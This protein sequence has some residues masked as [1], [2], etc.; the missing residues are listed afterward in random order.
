MINPFEDEI[1]TAPSIAKAPDDVIATEEE[2]DKSK[3]E[4]D[5]N[6]DYY[7]INLPDDKNPFKKIDA[8][9]WFTN[10]ESRKQ[11]AATLAEQIADEYENSDVTVPVIRNGK[12]EQVKASNNGV[13]TDAGQHALTQTLMMIDQAS[14]DPSGG[15]RKN[16]LTGKTEAAFGSKFLTPYN[17]DDKLAE[18]EKKRVAGE[19]GEYG[20]TEYQLSNDQVFDYGHVSKVIDAYAKIND[21]KP[22]ELNPESFDAKSFLDLRGKVKQALPEGMLELG[23]ELDQTKAPVLDDESQKIFDKSIER[24]FAEKKMGDK[25]VDVYDGQ[26]IVNYEALAETGDLKRFE[27]E[28]NALELTPSAKKI[29]LSSFKKEFEGQAASLLLKQAQGD[30]YSDDSTKPILEA[31]EK[32]QSFYNLLKEDPYAL[33]STGSNAL[34]FMK[35]VADHATSITAGAT[36]SIGS[37]GQM[38]LAGGAK[39]MGFDE[40]AADVVSGI[41]T[42]SDQIGAFRETRG[43]GKDQLDL[44]LFSVTTGDIHQLISEGAIAFATMGASALL[45]S[46]RI[47][48]TTTIKGA[49]NIGLQSAAKK[50][51][52]KSAKSALSSVSQNL[53]KSQ[54]VIGSVWKNAS[55]ARTLDNVLATTLEG[56]FRSAASAWG[57]SYQKNIDKGL[58]NVDAFNESTGQAVANG[59]ATFVAG[60]IMNSIAPGLDKINIAPDS[61]LSLTQAIKNTIAN[62]TAQKSISSGLKSFRNN[63]KNRKDLVK[64]VADTIREEA[65]KQGLKNYLGGV[66]VQGLGEGVEES[67]DAALAN[68]LDQYLNNSEEARKEFEKKGYWNQI[69]KAGFLGAIMGS[70]MSTISRTSDKNLQ[71]A[72]DAKAGM[73]RFMKKVPELA[74][75]ADQEIIV[76]GA[77]KDALEIKTTINQILQNGT[78]DQQVEA[79]ANI[80]KTRAQNLL[81]PT[82]PG[83]TQGTGITPAVD[84]RTPSAESKP[85]ATDTTPAP[86][87]GSTPIEQTA[88]P[89]KRSATGAVDFK[90]AEFNDADKGVSF[91]VSSNAPKSQ[92]LQLKIAATPKTVDGNVEVEWSIEKETGPS[93]GQY[94]K[95]R[96]DGRESAVRAF[97]E[98]FV[99]GIEASQKQAA[100]AD[101]VASQ[102]AVTALNNQLAQLR[103]TQQQTTT[104]T[105]AEAEPK[106]EAPTKPQSFTLTD[107][108]GGQSNVK[109]LVSKKENLSSYAYEKAHGT[110]APAGALEPKAKTTTAT[111]MVNGNPQSVPV[112]SYTIDGKDADLHS[113]TIGDNETVFFKKS[114]SVNA[115]KGAV[116]GASRVMMKGE[117]ASKNDYAEQ[118]QSTP[119]PAQ[120]PESNQPEK[121]SPESSEQTT[122]SGAV[123]TTRT[124]LSTGQEQVLWKKTKYGRKVG[125][126]WDA[127]FPETVVSAEDK[128]TDGMPEEYTVAEVS[129]ILHGEKKGGEVELTIRDMTPE[130]MAEAKSKMEKA[131]A[132]RR[133]LGI[134]EEVVPE[135]PAA[136]TP[137]TE[138]SKPKEK[139]QAPA[140]S[141]KKK[142]EVDEDDGPIKGVNKL[143]EPLRKIVRKF[144]G[145]A[146]NIGAQIIIVKDDIDLEKQMK[147]LGFDDQA[148][149]NVGDSPMFFSPDDNVIIVR[150]NRANESN[151]EKGIKHEIFH[152]VEKMFAASDAG[153]KLLGEI[154]IAKLVNDP[155]VVEYMK[156]EYS[157]SYPDMTNNQK[158]G[159]ITRAFVAGK[160]HKNTL[161]QTAFQ[162]YLKAFLK[163]ARKFTKK[164]TEL[165]SYLDGLEKF[166]LDTLQDYKAEAGIVASESSGFKSWIGG[167][168]ASGIKAAKMKL[169]GFESTSSIKASDEDIARIA[170]E[171]RG[172]IIEQV[173]A[174]AAFNKPLNAVTLLENIS[175]NIN[176]THLG[177]NKT[178]DANSKIAV[179]QNVLKGLEG[180][181]IDQTVKDAIASAMESVNSDRSDLLMSAPD[182]SQEVLDSVEEKKQ[183]SGWTG[184]RRYIKA[185]DLFSDVNVVNRR[186]FPDQ[187]PEVGE[188]NEY[189]NSYIS[190]DFN[191]EAQSYPDLGL[192]PG[193]VVEMIDSLGN[194]TGVLV[195]SHSVEVASQ[196]DS[197]KRLQYRF[198]KGETVANGKITPFAAI[199]QAQYSQEFY[200]MF[201]KSGIAKTMFGDVNGRTVINTPEGLIKM[202]FESLVSKNAKGKAVIKQGDKTLSFKDIF[203]FQKDKDNKSLT[204]F[205]FNAGDGKIY[206]DPEKLSANFAFIDNSSLDSDGKRQ[207]MALLVASTVRAAIEEEL[208]HLATVGT[209]TQ[210]EL[211]EFADDLLQRNA[212]EG[213]VYQVR[214]M[215][216]ITSPI[217]SMTDGEKAI[218]A[219][220]VLSFLHQKSAEGATYGDQYE[221]LFELAAG[222]GSA[223][224]QTA[225][226]YGR[227]MRYMLGARAATSF[228][229]PRMQKMVEVLNSRKAE[230]GVNRRATNM[231]ELIARF[232]QEQFRGSKKAMQDAI[233]QAFVNQAAEV[234]DL[235]QMLKENDIPVQNVLNVDFELNTVSLVPEFSDYYKLKYG[236]KSLNDLNDYFSRLNQNEA[237]G[238]LADSVRTA[239]SR[240]DSLRLLMDTTSELDRLVEMATNGNFDALSEYLENPENQGVFDFGSLIQVLNGLKYDTNIAKGIERDKARIENAFNAVFD[241]QKQ[242]ANKDQAIGYL[243]NLLS[244]YYSKNEIETDLEFVE[245]IA[246]EMNQSKEELIQTLQSMA[247]EQ[248]GMFASNENS[249]RSS[250]VERDS[251]DKL[252]ALL[253]EKNN[254]QPESPIRPTYYSYAQS[255]SD[256]NDLVLNYADILLNKNLS[257]VDE[258]GRN[259]ADVTTALENPA[260]TLTFNVNLFGYNN[261]LAATAMGHRA[262]REK[263]LSD[264]PDD[265][266]FKATFAYQQAFVGRIISKDRNNAIDKVVRIES[267]AAFLG[268]EAYNDFWIARLSGEVPTIGG[269]QISYKDYHTTMGFQPLIT[270]ERASDGTVE[271]EDLSLYLLKLRIPDAE[272]DFSS[273]IAGK[274]PSVRNFRDNFLKLAQSDVATK[275]TAARL[276]TEQLVDVAQIGKWIS[277]L[278]DLIGYDN[279]TGLFDVVESLNNKETFASKFAKQLIYRIFDNKLVVGGTKGLT[280][281]GADP[282]NPTLFEH[283][284]LIQR[285]YDATH[286]G[287]S[288]KKEVNK[289]DQDLLL[290]SLPIILEQ[291]DALNSDIG[292]ARKANSR[293]KSQYVASTI[294]GDIRLIQEQGAEGIRANAELIKA[295]QDSYFDIQAMEDAEWLTNYHTKNGPV[296][297]S[298]VTA[299]QLIDAFAKI[300]SS[301]MNEY[302]VTQGIQGTNVATLLQR[303]YQAQEMYAELGMGSPRAKDSD[304]KTTYALDNLTFNTVERV[305]DR[306][307]EADEEFN[308]D[309][310]ALNRGQETAGTMPQGYEGTQ[311]QLESQRRKSLMEEVKRIK[312][313]MFASSVS[314]FQS[315]DENLELSYTSK[316]NTNRAKTFFRL[317]AEA[318][319]NGESNNESKQRLLNLVRDQMV[320]LHYKYNTNEISVDSPFVVIADNLFNYKH[321]MEFLLDVAEAIAEKER[322]FINDLQAHSKD[323]GVMVAKELGKNVESKK[324]AD[325]NGDGNIDNVNAL[326]SESLLKSL[327][328]DIDKG[329]LVDGTLFHAQMFKM[330]SS[331]SMMDSILLEKAPLFSS[332]LQSMPNLIIYQPSQYEGKRNF[333]EN[334]IEF[335]TLPN[336]DV[337]LYIGNATGLGSSKQAELLERVLTARI[338]Q[339]IG[340]NGTQSPLA[341]SIKQIASTIREQINYVFSTTPERI[342]QM[343]EKAFSVINGNPN[344]PTNVVNTLVERYRKALESDA[345]NKLSTLGNPASRDKFVSDIVGDRAGDMQSF[346]DNLLS[347]DLEANENSILQDMKLIVDMFTNPDTYK[348]LSAIKSPEVELTSTELDP[349]YKEF[350]DT[351]INRFVSEEV[352]SSMVYDIK[353]E[354]GANNVFDEDNLG[355]STPEA[356]TT[357]FIVDEIISSWSDNFLSG[358]P[359]DDANNARKEKQIKSVIE[360]SPLD[361]VKRVVDG[362]IV[363]NEV[364]G[365]RESVNLTYDQIATTTNI[366]KEVAPTPDFMFEFVFTEMVHA[367]AP[368]NEARSV[369]DGTAPA[370]I[371]RPQ[372]VFELLQTSSKPVLMNSTGQGNFRSSYNIT[373]F[374][375]NKAPTTKLFEMRRKEAF[376]SSL[377]SATPIGKELLQYVY[378]GADKSG[379][380][381]VQRIDL[382]DAQDTL[383]A[384]RNQIKDIIGEDIFNEA[385]EN[386]EILESRKQ[387]DIEDAN[388]RIE[389]LKRQIQALR[390]DG[391]KQLEQVLLANARGNYNE[392]IDTILDLAVSIA[393]IVHDI[394]QKHEVATSAVVK[395][396]SSEGALEKLNNYQESITQLER[397]DKEI[398]NHLRDNSG[399]ISDPVAYNKAYS[400]LVL[401]HNA[402]AG[403]ARD[404]LDSYAKEIAQSIARNSFNKAYDL[405]SDVSALQEAVAQSISRGLNTYTINAETITLQNAASINQSLSRFLMTTGR[406][407]NAMNIARDL[408]SP[409][410]VSALLERVQSNQALTNLMQEQVDAIIASPD[411]NDA[412][413]ELFSRL[414]KKELSKSMKEIVSKFDP[415]SSLKQISDLVT[416]ELLKN[417]KLVDKLG[418]EVFSGDVKMALRKRAEF[419]SAELGA[420]REDFSDIIAGNIAKQI[421]DLND[422]REALLKAL[423]RLEVESEGESMT[424]M[425]LSKKFSFDEMF[426]I[427]R[428]QNSV[429]PQFDARLNLVFD[430]RRLDNSPDSKATKKR[431]VSSVAI[432]NEAA[433]LFLEKEGENMHRA[434]YEDVEMFGQGYDLIQDFNNVIDLARLRNSL[435][436][437]ADEMFAFRADE[438]LNTL[439]TEADE[440]AVQLFGVT[441]QDM[442]TNNM[443]PAVVEGTEEG[444]MKLTTVKLHNI[445][446]KKERLRRTALFINDQ[447][448]SSMFMPTTTKLA[449][450]N[451]KSYLVYSTNARNELAKNKR[452]TK[453]DWNVDE[454]LKELIFQAAQNPPSRGEGGLKTQT[455]K[456]I[457]T[458]LNKQISESLA[459]ETKLPKE[460]TIGELIKIATNRFT[461]FLIKN[462]IN[463]EM[464]AFAQG[465][466]VNGSIKRTRAM[467]DEEFETA[468]DDVFAFASNPDNDATLQTAGFERLDK[469]KSDY[470]LSE[471]KNLVEKAYAAAIKENDFLNPDSKVSQSIAFYEK[472]LVDI[473]TMLNSDEIGPQMG[474]F[475]E[476]IRSAERSI[477]K[478]VNIQTAVDSASE[479]NPYTI[480]R[481]VMDLDLSHNWSR[482]YSIL[483]GRETLNKL[484]TGALNVKT[485]D[486][487]VS[488]FGI[489]ENALARRKFSR[490]YGAYNEALNLI[491]LLDHG[492]DGSSGRNRFS[493]EYQALQG[494]LGQASKDLD[495]DFVK[496]AKAMVIASLRGIAVANEKDNGS[497]AQYAN[498]VWMWANAWK[499]GMKQHEKLENDRQKSH[500]QGNKF[501][502]FS[503]RVMKRGRKQ[504]RERAGTELINNLITDEVNSIVNIIN[505]NHTKPE[506]L[507]AR[508]EAMISKLESGYEPSDLAAI[509]KYS[510]ALLSEFTEI[511]EAYRITQA[512]ASRDNRTKISDE[513]LLDSTVIS[514][515]L[516]K[517]YSVFPLRFGYVKNPLHVSHEAYSHNKAPITDFIG[518]EQGVI[519]YQGKRTGLMEEESDKDAIRPLDLNP[520][521]APDQIAKDAMYRMYVAPTY[522][523]I[524]KLLG[525]SSSDNVRQSI[526]TNGFL[527]GVANATN[528]DSETTSQYPYIA[529]YIMDTIDKTIKNDKPESV[530]DSMLSDYLRAAATLI[531]VKYLVEPW[532]IVSQGVIPAVS[533]YLTVKLNNFIGTTDKDTAI[534]REAYKDAVLGYRNPNSPIARFVKENSIKNYKWMTEGTDTRQEQIS[535]TKYEGESRAVYVSRK[536]L[537][538]SKGLGEGSLDVV[539]GAPER[540]NIQAIYAFEL[541]HQLQKMMGPEAPKTL[542]EMY[543]MDPSS[544]NTLAKTKAD[545][546]VTDF[547]GLGDKSKKAGAYNIRSKS[548]IVSMIVQSFT[549]FSNHTATVGANKGVFAEY[550]WNNFAARQGYASPEFTKEAIENITGTFIQNS[551][552][553]VTKLPFLVA[554]GTYAASL[555]YEIVEESF[556]DDDEEDEDNLESIAQRASEWA[557]ALTQFDENG[558]LPLQMLKEYLFPKNMNVTN[559]NTI[560]EEGYSGAYLD[561]LWRAGQ[562]IVFDNIDLFPNSTASSITSFIPVKSLVKSLFDA[563]FEAGSKFIF[564]EEESDYAE[565]QKKAFQAERFAETFIMPITEPI[566]AANNVKNLMLNYALPK[567]GYEGISTGE[568]LN[569]IVTGLLGTR[570]S[571][572]SVPKRHAEQGGWGVEN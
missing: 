84:T 154:D 253:K 242:V 434:L 337:V 447:F 303:Y 264:S 454:K 290:S 250:I 315:F 161:G 349:K 350:F 268:E 316:I 3:E 563:A 355:V 2:D 451:N 466:R 58:S 196:Q 376:V 300:P 78:L 536:A 372:N 87:T 200:D 148:I 172:D 267:N 209:F 526:T 283:L 276:I 321:P 281:N 212:F 477:G 416:T 173:N 211:I 543:Q 254:A 408:S 500:E 271:P 513:Q 256:Y 463:K 506:M 361:L 453:A 499:N 95:M 455:H 301:A 291:I 275:E 204:P 320:F 306:P 63:I 243:S 181:D 117:L 252:L 207:S 502:R 335:A 218:V 85:P 102:S 261:E 353:L 557:T 23:A 120:K 229:S 223:R 307:S 192:N 417:P 406:K 213:I 532:Q 57:E 55:K 351:A 410:N 560:A 32:G 125:D 150:S 304:G 439:V 274:K 27:S 491:G 448:S 135:I 41:A 378:D 151:F 546:L 443:S 1:F 64:G 231:S 269:L 232:N 299:L 503:N 572:R 244:R 43:F 24:Y 203:V 558:F 435:Q 441:V 73:A 37:I 358:E 68:A 380:Y 504:D 163:F 452:Q 48:A 234:N 86:E 123:F 498:R 523:V 277:D 210:K 384:L 482:L 478:L 79:I 438:A 224:I 137:T 524:N 484:V 145:I 405:I 194:V 255:V 379:Q 112:T 33:Q 227:R 279:K 550:L 65:S 319:V 377:A 481:A 365:G 313:W 402:H 19:K 198:I 208:L 427:A 540:A 165:K 529:A 34:D 168:L 138:T 514:D 278:Q 566:I 62:R 493:A 474:S 14:K 314:I 311:E 56:S 9:S 507:N 571:R 369:L 531:A 565:L 191:K 169:S 371:G 124:R 59:L 195:Y 440:K 399:L 182:E 425:Q 490:N 517:N 132:Q 343:E 170:D 118:L 188:Q 347:A 157:K 387:K 140:P 263:A 442:V 113:V 52:E 89:F 568:F 187:D 199:R 436:F 96:A 415:K 245:R 53:I 197:V 233:N 298:G 104:E 262:A 239:R 418:D 393:G 305:G 47:A 330:G 149:K 152:A 66:A 153:K 270:R 433:R 26:P 134:K 295:I 217:D 509:R 317:F 246:S 431:I 533:K 133:E 519:N 25:L 93:S 510:D 420:E 421:D 292:L 142:E 407:A 160:L 280:V 322:A 325:L 542:Q 221:E 382:I 49:V 286:P 54:S 297:Y 178:M 260:S 331:Q 492:L 386:H 476:Y 10:P 400:V 72:E 336:N 282:M 537:A 333:I 289:N 119:P 404:Y 179:L 180:A 28:L 226:A 205:Y 310:P 326:A 6:Y 284:Q 496:G 354:Q 110:K 535:L 215:Q 430:T 185:E 139:S 91:E 459:N 251:R 236:E 359:K 342:R 422:Q 76:Q 562:D 334:N 116:Q 265:A 485:D 247:R 539:I 469:K 121:Y 551:L 12:V 94:Q 115:I 567:D 98:E 332:L 479:A 419:A 383:A 538:L 521:T 508:I 449:E 344:I 396:A 20:A 5:K 222:K 92:G 259:F 518:M 36:S 111:V 131:N 360:N 171:V 423:A 559:E 258:F 105:N 312:S 60:A 158:F 141:K 391:L 309:R 308:D 373:N 348:I 437:R 15:A 461:S 101:P 166:Y 528:T 494:R 241:P 285:V 489:H 11:Q 230:M 483:Y 409:S 341:A 164:N 22:D 456:K 561:M 475:A 4:V 381:A 450:E 374:Y 155:E 367:L 340:A 446:Q 323:I 534:L 31:A 130:E 238:N 61:G 516:S 50:I 159:E 401:N 46:S 127:G 487:K 428:I 570:N 444:D 412:V 464:G 77:K 51:T 184:V 424:L 394:G 488:V 501:M 411:T 189:T 82:K 370:P 357:S 520:F 81:S 147:S 345:A 156:K 362:L 103:P 457:T 186:G 109:A 385:V 388:A 366:L 473:V 45:S 225:K 206:V 177:I 114:D 462:T 7:G 480:S 569:G 16:P 67:M 83:G 175:K 555:L 21:V 548:A 97:G 99:A 272:I 522:K 144:K 392:S 515:V 553:I 108:T 266:A 273:K 240:M 414:K 318:Q 470:S 44:G 544:I 29:F 288:G 397:I 426:T 162:K 201:A 302:F 338:K 122:E 296:G 363:V 460:T 106:E 183:L 136:K 324:Q 228:M 398:K 35:R 556:F 249:A 237:V 146:S 107:N 42:V 495:N 219:T 530:Q 429:S 547:M 287:K 329:K 13:L 505:I 395:D 541:F 294:M 554:A 71:I 129:R 167:I 458:D 403:H 364:K 75:Y 346:L 100:G 471:K 356:D 511:S 486:G 293:F 527:H 413:K 128:T 328:E 564:G 220:E 74:K 18:R 472:Q 8:A 143:A 375:Y 552:F 525:K 497:N 390:E 327:Q 176:D 193:D 445:I 214:K 30:I 202:V 90:T 257:E 467:S 17:A 468:F 235:R 432:I 512:F 352:Q 368:H 38:F 248:G 174:A 545:I 339:E 40:Y 70:G 88:S 216:R 465:I 126:K 549:R 389:E 69:I 80:G 39:A 190:V